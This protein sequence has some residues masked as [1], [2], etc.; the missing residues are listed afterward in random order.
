MLVDISQSRQKFGNA[1]NAP[2]N[3]PLNNGAITQLFHDLSQ[4]IRF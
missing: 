1:L 4:Q 3:E 2:F